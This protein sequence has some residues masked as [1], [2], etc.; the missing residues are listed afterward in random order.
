MQEVAT[1][2]NSV[3]ERFIVDGIKYSKLCDDKFYSQKLFQ[4]EE[5]YGYLNDNLIESTK[6]IFDYVVYDSEIEER[7]AEGLEKDPSVLL[8]GKLPNWFKIP[9]PLGG[10][11]PDWAI[12][13]N[14]N[15]EEKFYFVAETKSTLDRSKL[16]PAENKKIDCGTK[17]FEVLDEKINFIV[18][19][20]LDDVLNKIQGD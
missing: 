3:K 11:N 16:R 8:Y 20:C 17:H 12:L 2:I 5:V 9:T 13:I 10:Y 15:G 6:G 19:T 18:A 1:I 4:V 7:F 14:D